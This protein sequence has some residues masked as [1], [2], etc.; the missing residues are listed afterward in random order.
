MLAISPESMADA[1][2][3]E[4]YQLR[5]QGFIALAM[6]V[7]TVML[8]FQRKSQEV[9]GFA[10]AYFAIYHILITLSGTINATMG[11]DFTPM[12]LHVV[13]GVI[14]LILWVKRGQL[15]F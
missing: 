12:M 9:I 4:I 7:A 11:F 5:N 8:W 15:E 2:I 13:F 3:T 10:T 1:T 14:F 6:G